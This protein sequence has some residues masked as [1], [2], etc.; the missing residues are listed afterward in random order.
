MFYTIHRTPSPRLVAAGRSGISLFLRIQHCA[1]PKPSGH[2]VPPRNNCG[3]LWGF[4]QHLK[5]FFS[6]EIVIISE[7]VPT[8]VV[9]RGKKAIWFIMLSS[10]V[11]HFLYIAQ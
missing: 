8:Y 5:I 4:K 2:F 3:R 6:L 7:M 11:D 10:I 1:Q 9:M